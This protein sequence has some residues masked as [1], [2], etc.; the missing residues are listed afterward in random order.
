MQTVDDAFGAI[1]YPDEADVL[2]KIVSQKRAEKGIIS[3]VK[4]WIGPW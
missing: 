1:F 2:F 4:R 3:K